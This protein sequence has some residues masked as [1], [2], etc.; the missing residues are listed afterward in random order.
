[1]TSNGEV[2]GPPRSARSEPRVHTVFPHPR[3]HYR[4]SRPPPTIVRR[5]HC[6]RR[7]IKT[8]HIPARGCIPRPRTNLFNAVI[9][10][11]GN[12]DKGFLPASGTCVS[13]PALNNE[14]LRVSHGV[15]GDFAAP[16]VEFVVVHRVD[17]VSLAKHG[18]DFG[19]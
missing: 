10:C 18:C 12:S 8:I 17:F 14:K 4:V 3:R 11:E 7:A 9:E 15:I 1:M 6:G 5:R 13:G 2:E 19:P 16:N